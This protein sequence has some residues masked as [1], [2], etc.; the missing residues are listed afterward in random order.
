MHGA[1][2]SDHELEALFR[3]RVFA[4]VLGSGSGTIAA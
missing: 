3:S 4:V 2:E 1:D